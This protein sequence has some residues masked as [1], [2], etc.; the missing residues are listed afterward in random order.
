MKFCLTILLLA[1]LAIATVPAN[2]AFA[3]KPTTSE[4]NDDA[5]L[6]DLQ[7]R[8]KQRLPKLKELKKQ[9]II[10]ETYEGYVDFVKGKPKDAEKLVKEENADRKELYTTIAQR[11]GTT[12]EKVAERNGK[13]NFTKATPGEFLRDADGKWHQKT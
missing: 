6:K 3:A 12:P 13:R 4:S 11:E 10:G 7:E 5:R 2:V 1:M 8:F 9:G